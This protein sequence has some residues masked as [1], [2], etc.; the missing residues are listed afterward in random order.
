MLTRLTLIFALVCGTGL[1][2]T[3]SGDVYPIL[4]KRCQGCHQAGEIGPMAFTNYQEVRPWAKAIK[5]SVVTRRMPPWHAS[6]RSGLQFHNDRSLTAEEIRTIVHWVDSGAPEGTKVNYPKPEQKEGS[7]KLGEPDVVFR[8]PG[9]KIPARGEIPNTFLILPLNLTEDR[10]IRA[11]EFRIDKRSAVHHLNVFVRPP[12]SSYLEGLPT[13]QFV[14]PTIQ[15]RRDPRAGEGMFD[16]RELLVGYEPGYVPMSWAKDGAKLIR[17]GSHLV[18]E[19]HY[20]AD[21]RELTDNS[22]VGL[23]FDKAKP[24]MRVLSISTQDLGIEIPP[25]DADFA[26]VASVQLQRPVTLLALQPHMHLR[27]KAMEVLARYPSGTAA[28]LLDVERYDF[29]WQTTYM[30]KAPLTLPG[31]TTL[32]STARFDNSRNNPFNP[33]SGV[34][35]RWGDQSWDEMHI[36]FIEI[37]FDSG[38]DPETLL[39]PKSPPRARSEVQQ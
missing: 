12:G 29:K 5:E 2:A 7:W 33:D 23:Y 9:Y 34:K 24:P 32:E 35:V 17:K 16:R 8:V 14:L 28:T 13:N 31:G 30:L 27:G 36:C 37:A 20:T 3:F 18:L 11:A 22:E 15:Q 6:E 10:W 39:V 38:I 4:R 26:S 25:G 19:M 21:G 1:S